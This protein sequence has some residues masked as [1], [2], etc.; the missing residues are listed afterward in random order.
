M[1]AG[2]LLYKT[3]SVART[4]YMASDE[5]GRKTGALDLVL[6]DSIMKARETGFRYFDLGT[7][8]LKQG[9]ILNQNLYQFKTEFGAG[10][11]VFEQFQIAL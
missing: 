11:V 3:H 8:N 9:K 10:G 4:Q 5:D 7:S 1:V 2:T 6:E